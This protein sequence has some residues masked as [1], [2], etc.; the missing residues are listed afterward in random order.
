[1]NN[2]PDWCKPVTI[3][4]ILFDLSNDYFHSVKELSWL[5]PIQILYYDPGEPIILKYESEVFEY[6]QNFK[7]NDIQM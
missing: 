4:L 7:W 6:S 2:V 3:S 5:Y 1:M